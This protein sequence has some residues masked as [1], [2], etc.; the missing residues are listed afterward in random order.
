MMS[1][2]ENSCQSCLMPMGDNL[3]KAGTEKNGE[4]SKIY[5]LYCYNNGQFLYEG[6]LKS[7][8]KIC[9]T[10]MKKTGMNSIK[11]WFFS[12]MIRFAPR[13]NKSA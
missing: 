8:Q 5:C 3:E 1:C 4:K 9:F 11:A 13:W 12:Q 2:P 6:D 7:F 10:E